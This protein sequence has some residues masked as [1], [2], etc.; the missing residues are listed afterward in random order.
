MQPS[1]SRSQ[2]PCARALLEERHG[3]APRQ[4]FAVGAVGGERVVGVAGGHDAH[5]KR[6]GVAGKPVR[7][8]AAVRPLVVVADEV[9]DRLKRLQPAADLLAG[10]GMPADLLHL[11]GVQAARLVQD[12]VRRADLAD[13]VQDGAAAQLAAD[14]FVKAHDPRDLGDERADAFDVA[15]GA[16]V[17]G[18]DGA[19]E[20]EEHVLGLVEMVLEHLHAQHRPDA[21]H[22]L[23]LPERL[24]QVLVRPGI[25]AFLLL[26]RGGQRG[27]EDDR[28]EFG[29][30]LGLQPAAQLDA[31][32]DR[33]ADIA[34][35]KVRRSILDHPQRLGAIARVGNDIPALL[36]ESS[37]DRVDRR[38]VVHH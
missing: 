32:H 5:R 29:A 7:I 4:R 35:D 24:G 21:G 31:V 2:I 33:H 30:R 37:H 34:E 14:R 8:A 3:L 13:I 26:V 16:M 20:R 10:I 18:L 25:Q 15:A 17:P 23:G 38:V 6:D 12:R 36:A 9:E 28:Q 27:K 11:F 19:G 22:A 1:T